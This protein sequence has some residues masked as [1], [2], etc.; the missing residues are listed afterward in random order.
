MKRNI[1][2]YC[3]L[4]AIALGGCNK[5]TVADNSVSE[6]VVMQAEQLPVL[7]SSPRNYIPTAIVY[8]TNGNYNDNV[9]VG[10]NAAGTEIT[11]FPAPTDV[12]VNSAPVQ[13]P[14][15]Y[16]LDR[17][18]IGPST[19][20]LNITYSE[21]A[22]LPAPPS[23]EEMKAMLIP[24]A[25][26]TFMAMLPVTASEAR[27]DPSVAEKYIADGFRDCQLLVK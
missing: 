14:D 15:G 24:G 8:K 17:R 2:L 10:I 18:G 13:L 16:L 4:G 11:N 6:E 25:E 22:A 21:Y 26:I 20:F 5:K 19:G 12:N 9:A 1:V 23:P 27:R 7:D 3:A